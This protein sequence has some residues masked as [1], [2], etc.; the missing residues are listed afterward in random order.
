MLLFPVVG[1][2]KEKVT[3]HFEGWWLAPRD[4]TVNVKPKERR[5]INHDSGYFLRSLTEATKI[6]SETLHS[7]LDFVAAFTHLKI[8]DN[9]FH[10]LL[11][12]I[13]QVLDGVSAVTDD[14]QL[15]NLLRLKNLKEVLT[16]WSEQLSDPDILTNL[17]VA[18][19]D[20]EFWETVDLGALVQWRVLKSQMKF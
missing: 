8:S 14:K 4:F 16:G 11:P 2:G 15:D 6:I 13:D 12:S 1:Y 5:G 3:I 9:D 18:K 7:V 17:K 10:L 19:E 20:K